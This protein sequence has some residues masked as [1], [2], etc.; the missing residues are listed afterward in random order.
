MNY[1]QMNLLVSVFLL[2]FNKSDNQ[3]PFLASHVH[4]FKDKDLNILLCIPQVSLHPQL[5]FH[6]EIPTPE[7]LLIRLNNFPI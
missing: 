3:F 4:I 2:A 6:Q 5:N 7:L 1:A